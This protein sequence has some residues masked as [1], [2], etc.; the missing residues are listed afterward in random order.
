MQRNRKVWFIHR[1]KKKEAREIAFE[2]TKIW[3]LAEKDVKTTIINMF[4]E[5]K[6][7]K[8]QKH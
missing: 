7:R 8:K 4:K 2:K 1:K 3:D 5:L 6:D